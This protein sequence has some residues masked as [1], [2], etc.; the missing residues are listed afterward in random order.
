MEINLPFQQQ[1]RQ[2]LHQRAHHWHHP[3]R[4][5]APE[6]AWRGG[7]QVLPVAMLDAGFILWVFTSL[8]KTL[9]QLQSRRAG[10]KL[11]LYRRETP[12]SLARELMSARTSPCSWLASACAQAVHQLPGADGVGERGVDRLRDVLQGMPLSPALPVPSATFK[13]DWHACPKQ[14][15]LPWHP[16]PACLEAPLRA[17]GD[18]PVQREVALRLDHQRLLVQPQLCVPVRHLLPVP[19]VLQLHALRILRAGGWGPLATPPPAPAERTLTCR[20]PMQ[21]VSR[22]HAPACFALVKPCCHC[23]LRGPHPWVSRGPL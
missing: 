4:L 7:A 15:A 17:A 1:H 3:W 22:G 5:R 10:A 11:D 6:V 9:S 2:G 14:R 16:L 23:Q 12:F 19:A 18:R 8:S 13:P 21:G 20:I